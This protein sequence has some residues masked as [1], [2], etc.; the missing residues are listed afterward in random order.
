MP[1]DSNNATALDGVARLIDDLDPVIER[2]DQ[3]CSTS[4]PSN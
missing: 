4:E 3:L 2:Y 1:T